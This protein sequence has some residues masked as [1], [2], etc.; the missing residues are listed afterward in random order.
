MDKSA[1]II[2]RRG[3]GKSTLQWWMAKGSIR[4]QEETQW[5]GTT[6]K[7]YS[8]DNSLTEDHTVTIIDS[9]CY[10]SDWNNDTTGEKQEKLFN[11]YN[12]LLQKSSTPLSA[13]VLV[14]P[15]KPRPKVKNWFEFIRELSKLFEKDVCDLVA[16]HLI[17]VLNDRSGK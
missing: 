9:P 6:R 10:G 1:L 4:L 8:V 13:L 16:K 11:K 12:Q 5:E 17:I 2:G 3:V 15:D 14:M 7:H